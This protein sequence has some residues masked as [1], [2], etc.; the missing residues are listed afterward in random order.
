MKEAYLALKEELEKILDAGGKK[1]FKTVAVESGQMAKIRGQQNTEGVVNFPAIFIKYENILHDPK[2]RGLTI[3][4][5]TVRVKIVMHEVVHDELAIFDVVGTVNKAIILGKETHESIVTIEK[6]LDE[7][8]E[9]YD[10]ILEWN[11]YY[12]LTFQDTSGDIYQDYVNANDPQVN[13]E[14]PV[15]YPNFVNEADL[16]KPEEVNPN[17][18][19]DATIASSLPSINTPLFINLVV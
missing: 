7:Q 5:A 8:P 3:G 17:P 6:Y 12:K 2:Q 16:G 14:A 19:A 10:N 18:E 9:F 4:N 13:P 1:F 11:A 15:L